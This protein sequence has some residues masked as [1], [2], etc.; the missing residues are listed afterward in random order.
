MR[1]ARSRPTTSNRMR[2]TS[3]LIKSA[4]STTCFLHS[5]G[6]T[7]AFTLTTIRCLQSQSQSTSKKESSRTIAVLGG[8]ISG[9]ASALYLTRALKSSSQLSKQWKIV[10]IEK[11]N[12]LGGWVKSQRISLK[13]DGEKAE[14]ALLESG[15]RSLRP[16]GYS[17]LVMLELVSR[18]CSQL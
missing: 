5:T 11:E 1:I 14:T 8:G 12:R 3:G 18:L 15:P 17:G 16:A 2:I 13:G 4:T 10:L 9:L 7:P 6:S